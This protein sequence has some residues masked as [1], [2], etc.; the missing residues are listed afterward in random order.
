MGYKLIGFGYPV[1]SAGCCGAELRQR[2]RQVEVREA[3][4]IQQR[5]NGTAEEP[6]ATAQLLS[7]LCAFQITLMV[8]R[9]LRCWADMRVSQ[10]NI[11]YALER[12]RV[13]AMA[14]CF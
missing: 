12:Y 6:A 7:L 1:Y 2:L 3:H 4:I 13:S 9:I 8:T 5:K 11:P 10:T 14:V